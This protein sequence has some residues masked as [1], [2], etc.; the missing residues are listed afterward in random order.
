MQHYAQEII[1]KLGL[2][3]KKSLKK[4]IR[5]LK[6]FN[7]LELVTALISSASIVEAGKLLGYSDNPIKQVIRSELMTH[8]IFFDREREFGIGGNNSSWRFA[9]LKL[10]GRKYCYKCNCVKLFSE[11]HS[12][13]NKSLGIEAECAICKNIRNTLDKE[14]IALRTPKWSESLEI[15]DFYTRCPKGYHVDHVIPLRGKLV[16]GLHVLG[17]LQYLPAYENLSKSNTY[18]I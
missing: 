14:Y 16:S 11:F 8:S 1:N 15:A 18:T 4:R 10:I 7:T 12:N 13:K 9:L 17:N 2:D 5:G 3:P 6:G